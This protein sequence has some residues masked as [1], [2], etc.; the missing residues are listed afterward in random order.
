[1]KIKKK[2]Q[3]FDDGYGGGGCGVW[4]VF[5]EIKRLNPRLDKKRYG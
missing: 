1:M 2:T 3:F 5:K 4:L